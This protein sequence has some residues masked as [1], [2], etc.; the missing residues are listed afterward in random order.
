[1]LLIVDAQTITGTEITTDELL[2]IISLYR[3]MNVF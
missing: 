2:Y 1:M 3:W